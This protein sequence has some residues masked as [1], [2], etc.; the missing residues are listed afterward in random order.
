M[1]EEI[2]VTRGTGM[3]AYLLVEAVMHRLVVAGIIERKEIALALR[4]AMAAAAK[5]R[6]SQDPDTAEPG[7]IAERIIRS[8][9]PPWESGMN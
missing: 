9:L 6:D 3:A 5:A 8:R 1:D 7:K 2:A 4:A